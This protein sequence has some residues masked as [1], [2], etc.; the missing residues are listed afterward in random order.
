[1]ENKNLSPKALSKEKH[2]ISAWITPSLKKALIFSL[3][4]AEN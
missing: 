2:K 1:M 4:N 3:M